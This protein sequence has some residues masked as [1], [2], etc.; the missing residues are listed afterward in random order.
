KKANR[1]LL[2]LDSSDAD[3]RKISLIDIWPELFSAEHSNIPI[4]KIYNKCDVSGLPCS[5]NQDSVTLSAKTGEGMD[6]LKE[7]LKEVMGFVEGVGRY[8]ARRRH[9]QSLKDAASH[10][11]LGVEI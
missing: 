10:I 4:T 7:H 8:S 1:I 6:L 11:A 5:K 3:A 2:V 9:L